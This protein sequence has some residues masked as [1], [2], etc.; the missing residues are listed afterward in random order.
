LNT[1]LI[2]RISAGLTLTMQTTL[3]SAYEINER[4]SIGGVLVSTIQCQDV[5]DA[6]GFSD[7]CEGAVPFQP[8]MSIRLTDSDELFFKLGYAAG[9]GLNNISPFESPPWAADMED[10]L[11]N[12]NGRNRDALLNAWYKHTLTVS[13]KQY[14]DFTMG[15]IDST[16][17]L[18]GNA[19]AND[20]YTQFMNSVLTNGPNVFLPSYDIGF[21][22]EWFNGH[23]T[24]TGVLMNVG[25]NDDGNNYDFYS[26]QVAYHANNS[27]GS[28]NYRILAAGTSADFLDPGGTE[29]VKRE[30]ALL[31]FDQEIGKV[32]GLWGR[33]GRETDH[34][35]IEH[36]AIYSGGFNFRGSGWGREGDN[37]GVGYAHFNGGSLNISHSHVAEAYYRWQLGEFLGLTVDVQHM[38]DEYKSG[39]ALDGWVYGLRAAIEF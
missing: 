34:A 7:T 37:I 6:P 17:Y 33:F 36:N 11:K 9:N 5:S 3:V 1:R 21:A 13:D 22:A 31:S 25:E 27:L 29:L 30:G 18:D 12:I 26:L 8:E 32:V 16:D 39:Q 2:T 20:E 4:L 19:Y 23:W 35:A 15:I 10:D 14:L 24:L 28:G 38:K